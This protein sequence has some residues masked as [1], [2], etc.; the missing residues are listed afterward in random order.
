MN[1]SSSKIFFLA[2]VAVIFGALSVSGQLTP[3]PPPTP[4]ATTR[5]PDH[6]FSFEYRTD[7]K[8]SEKSIKVDPALNLSLCVTQGDLR[9][10]G[11]SRDE[12][13][14]FIRNG[15]AFELLPQE[16][17]AN[18]TPVSV[19]VSGLMSGKGAKTPP[20]ECLWGSDIEIDVPRGTIVNVKGYET[21]TTIDVVRKVRVNVVGG[22]ISARNVAEG[23]SISAGQGDIMIENVKGSMQLAST[24]GNIVVFEGNPRETGDLFR[25]KTH[26]G[27]VSL[28]QVGYRDVEVTSISGSVLYAGKVING[29][30]YTFKT[31]NGS[32][33]LAVPSDSAARIAAS[34]G[35][36]TFDCE[37]P[38][39]IQEENVRPGS[40]K[41]VNGVLGKNGD[42]ILRLTTTNGSILIKKQ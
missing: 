42:A 23:V 9:I 12:L 18:G 32:I 26:G 24:T 34:Y 29:G 4:K 17:N 14:V 5:P 19:I 27:T 38:V 25:A 22:N 30:S 28:Q 10:N 20:S 31:S 36:G 6:G 39:Q 16:S 41:S 7:G 11:S 21:D 15:S 40:I 33:R 1:F 2:G 13:R 35:F 3:K 8:S 37:L